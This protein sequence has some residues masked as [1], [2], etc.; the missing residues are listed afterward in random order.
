MAQKELPL[1]FD[2]IRTFGQVFADTRKLIRENF[3]VF[4]R[5]MLFLVGPVALFTCT[6]HTFYEVNIIGDDGGEWS[7]IGSYTAAS[8]IYT[9]LRWFINGLVTAVVVSHFIKGYREK[10]PGKFDVNDITASLFRD[11]GGSFLTAMM[12]LVFVSILSIAVA[13]LIFGIARLSPAAGIFLI[14]LGYLGYFVLRFPLWYL[15]DSVFDVRFAVPGEP[16][17]VG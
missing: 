5:A 17:S 8:T 10:G 14:V 15:V 16:V 9:Q 12:M 7:Q 1:K 2:Q 3:S 4:F 13:G 11:F 6:I